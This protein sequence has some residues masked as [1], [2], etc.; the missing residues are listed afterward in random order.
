MK[1]EAFLML[2]GDV[3]REIRTCEEVQSLLL[4]KALIKTRL[5]TLDGN[6]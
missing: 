4:V 1:I 6:F 5:G 3:A 2:I